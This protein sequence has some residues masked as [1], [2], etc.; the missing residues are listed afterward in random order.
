MEK[1]NSPMLSNYSMY[2]IKLRHCS[3]VK[4]GIL[5]TC[6]RKWVGRFR[7]IVTVKCSYTDTLGF[8]PSQFRPYSPSTEGKAWTCSPKQTIRFT[9]IC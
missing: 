7:V 5:Q 9:D 6:N 1:N 4:I 2:L 3:K 8:C